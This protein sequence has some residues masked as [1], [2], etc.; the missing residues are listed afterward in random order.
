MSVALII[1]AFRYIFASEEYVE[2]TGSTYNDVFGFFITGPEM[3][4]G[5][6]LARA[7]GGQIERRGQRSRS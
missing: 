7:Q 4:K 2:F 1:I 3:E 6:N 5:K